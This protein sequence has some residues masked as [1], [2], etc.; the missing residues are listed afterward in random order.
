MRTPYPLTPFQV[1]FFAHD[2]SRKCA[3][4][5]PNRISPSI[6][7]A[8]IDLNPH[9]LDAALF[10]LQSPFA[11]GV[12]LA[13]EVGLG[14]TVE[15]GLL[16]AQ[17]W[18]EG[19]RRLLVVAPASLTRQWADELQE[20]FHLPA[21]VV[22]AATQKAPSPSSSTSPWV[23]DGVV[24]C[25]YHFAAARA[26][27]L[28]QEWWDLVVLDEAHRLR[29]AYKAGNRIGQ[30]L[31]DAFAKTQKILLTATPL[32]NSLMELYGLMSI[33]DGHLFGDANS[34]KFQYG[35]KR[36]DAALKPLVDRIA[37]YCRRTLRRDVSAYI[38]WTQRKAHLVQFRE[39]VEEQQLYNALSD[40]LA[41]PYLFAI[42]KRNRHLM[43]LMLRK[44]QASSPIALA[45]TLERLL[46]SL[47]DDVAEEVRRRHATEVFED[48]CDQFVAL[49][50]EWAE[51]DDSQSEDATDA[52]ASS[53][54]SAEAEHRVLQSL[55]SQA[56]GLSTCTKANA[57]LSA[58]SQAFVISRE[59]MNRAGQQRLQPKAIIFTESR[60]TQEYLA[61]RLTEVLPKEEILSFNGTNDNAQA[62]SIVSAWQ[63]AREGTDL[64]SG[65]YSVDARAALVEHFRSRASVMVATEAAA[66]GLNLQ[67][68][69]L[70]INYDLPWNP[71][72]IEQRIGRCHRYGQRCDVVVMNFLN[73]ANAADKRVYELLDTKCRLFEGVFGASDE[74]LGA[75]GTDFNFEKRIA[76]IYE[77]CRTPEEIDEGFARLQV[78]LDDQ[79]K[80]ARGA[81][82]DKLFSRFD[83]EVAERV[84]I[85]AARRRDRVGESLWGVT[86]HV[87]ASNAA[88]NDVDHSFTL[89]EQ[90]IGAPAFPLGRYALPRDEDVSGT[91]A[92][93][94]GH[95]LAR[96][97]LDQARAIKPKAMRVRV[98]EPPDR[99]G[100]AEG[101]CM[102]GLV[103]T[104]GATAAEELVVV[105]TG[106]TTCGRLLNFKSTVLG[107]ITPSE[108]VLGFL[109]NA[110]AAEVRKRT[111]K[112]TN[113]NLMWLGREK[114]KLQAWAKDREIS[115]EREI[116]NA[117]EK[118]RRAAMVIASAGGAA[119]AKGRAVAIREEQSARKKI[120]ELTELLLES[121]RSSS[122]EQGRMV[123]A[124]LKEC[125]VKTH[126]RELFV[127]HWRC[128]E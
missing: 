57:L 81:A 79:I 116:A 67:F 127:F 30:T 70:V 6:F 28:K 46:R 60:R 4:D 50:D 89:N 119:D 93:R 110:L 48:D 15:A 90:P 76:L 108:E 84:R 78:E 2:L 124:M 101:W 45:G 8:R 40:Y 72:R 54:W 82:I 66:E 114:S 62:R 96:W 61:E 37:P 120:V 29:N 118:A 41:K 94:M 12:L 26:P 43:A 38:K 58:L 53:A 25:S 44:L 88:F 17:R 105:C 75:I 34:F 87:L 121:R 33:L 59:A 74:I 10:A 32:Q 125:D 35:Q 77:S 19:R 113:R 24:I 21:T 27:G 102:C 3:P 92:Y 31:R 123:L 91:H 20:K 104:T 83:P 56:R 11:S 80:Q 51:D 106:T 14:K 55:V 42:P 103:T 1:C 71:Q 47:A 68:C 49:L 13:D 63:A 112:A 100:G 7:D 97:V 95:P 115:I 22:T 23:H 16:L 73:E 36:S 117:E 39:S 5:D 9:Q 69:N 109:R 122:D 107:E 18:A 99:V 86:R 126:S 64:V 128:V 52:S 65:N 98:H 111:E 85:D